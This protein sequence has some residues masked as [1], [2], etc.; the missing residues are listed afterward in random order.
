MLKEHMCVRNVNEYIEF[1][2]LSLKSS[3]AQDF[4]H[5]HFSNELLLFLKG[6]TKYMIDGQEY[7][8]QPYDMLIVPKGTYHYMVSNNTIPHVL[9]IINFFDDLLPEDVLEK[10]VKPPH[11]FNIKNDPFV[12]Q[13]LDAL[14]FM[15]NA[16]SEKDFERSC[17][18]LIREL[19]TYC[20]YM[21]KILVPS[22][23]QNPIID[24]ILEYISSHIE[25]PLDA[26]RISKALNLSP[27]HIQNTFSQYMKIGLKQYITQK[28]IIE[29][30]SAL[31]SGMSASDVA[32]KY[33]FNDYSTFYRVYKKSFGTSPSAYK[34]RI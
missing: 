12:T 26:E 27:S 13:F 22:S 34:K 15:Y 21:P 28:K 20:C 16:Y 25:E 11:I 1:L 14:R 3:F 32:A 18:G 9:N 17:E 5:M 33:H 19:L 2:S 29:A 10:L 8:L 6:S 23:N 7:H 31:L 30:Q 24:K 4:N